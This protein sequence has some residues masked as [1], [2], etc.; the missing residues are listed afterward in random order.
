[1]HQDGFVVRIVID[2]S[3][4]S[5]VGWWEVGVGIHGDSPGDGRG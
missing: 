1:M 5:R 4:D 2:G 3:S